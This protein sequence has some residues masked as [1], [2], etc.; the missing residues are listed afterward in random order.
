MLFQLFEDGK[1]TTVLEGEALVP[2][3][4]T[5]AGA[6]QLDAATGKLPLRKLVEIWNQLPGVQPVAR[7]ENRSIAVAR[8]WRSLQPGSQS[9]A[10]ASTAGRNRKPVHYREGSKAALV[11]EL[12]QRPEGAT[13]Q[14]ITAATGWQ[15]HS[16]RGFISA[17]LR[18]RGV[19]VRFLRRGEQ[20]AYQLRR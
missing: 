2:G 12:L 15:P 10:A 13:L 11:H 3:T 4:V 6:E 5:F 18:K 14:E 20:S 9:R 1:I 8:I 17:G 7:F 19:K 16:V